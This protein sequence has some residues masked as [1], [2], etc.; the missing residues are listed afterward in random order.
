MAN[1]A[2][3]DGWASGNMGYL[4]SNDEATTMGISYDL[5]DITL[6]YDMT[7]VTDDDDAS[8]DR[9]VTVM[10]LG[11]QLNSNCNLSISRFS[12]TNLEDDGSISG[13]VDDGERT[14]LTIS[15]GL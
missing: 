7:T 8:D 1:T 4:N 6:S 15:I 5:G 9:E 14:Y 13:N 12:D 2:T 3:S 11:Y 10:T